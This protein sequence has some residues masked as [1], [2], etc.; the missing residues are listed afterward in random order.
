MSAAADRKSNMHSVAFVAAMTDRIAGIW[1]G[2]L[3]SVFNWFKR[4]GTRADDLL[5]DRLQVTMGE[6]FLKAYTLLPVKACH[7]RGAP[8]V[9]GMVA[10]AGVRMTAA[11]VGFRSG[12]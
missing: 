6:A 3:G 5:P 10:P 2:R 4:I 7:R 1:R 9:I 12:F 11:P 8:A